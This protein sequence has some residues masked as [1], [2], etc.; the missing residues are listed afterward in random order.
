LSALAEDVKA[1]ARTSLDRVENE[2][3]PGAGKVDLYSFLRAEGK[4][5]TLG[6][7][8]DL[9]HRASLRTSLFAHGWL[10]TAW[11]AERSSELAGEV[12]AGLRMRW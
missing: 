6:V 11:S 1:A 7:G 2:L 4:D 3:T 8:L 9:E 10:G 5:G 12:L